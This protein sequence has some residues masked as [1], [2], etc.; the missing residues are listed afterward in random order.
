[1]T[2]GSKQ[3]TSIVCGLLLALPL[4][5]QDSPWQ[6][7]GRL[8]AH[9]EK[10]GWERAMACLDDGN[11]SCAEAA[12]NQLLSHTR[13]IG[14]YCLIRVNGPDDKRLERAFEALKADLDPDSSRM[15]S[16]LVPIDALRGQERYIAINTA[17]SNQVDMTI[18][19][20]EFMARI[21]ENNYS[22]LHSKAE[23]GG[24]DSQYELAMA[25]AN[26]EM[27]GIE[28]DQ[29]LAIQWFSRAAAQGYAPAEF[30]MGYSYE[31]GMGVPKDRIQASIWYGKAADHGSVSSMYRLGRLLSDNQSDPPDDIS[32]ANRLL[33][34]AADAGLPDAQNSIGIHYQYGI[35]FTQSYALATEWYR[36]AADQGHSWAQ[37]NLGMLAEEGLGGPK[38]HAA[39]VRWYEQAIA[40]DHPRAKWK[41]AY[42]LAEG[43]GV[44]QDPAR[45]KSLFEQAA[46]AGEPDGWNGL[47]Y[48]FLNGI[49]VN[50]SS[51]EALRHYLRSANAGNAHGMYR[52]SALL[53]ER[54]A[55]K[56][57]EWRTKAA[58]LG[59]VDAQNNN[60]A[61]YETGHGVEINTAWALY[62]YAKA[63]QQGSELAKQNIENL[64]PKRSHLTTSPNRANLR[65]EPSTSASV[66]ESLPRGTRV[67]PLDEPVPGWREVYVESG[68][69]LGYLSSSVLD[70]PNRRRGGVPTA[71]ND[72]WPARP[73]PRPGYVT[74]NT[75]CRNGDCRR[76]YSDGRRVRFQ[77]T[78]K[79]NPFSSQFEWDSGSC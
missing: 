72:G 14:E 65:A 11:R 42:L 27:P 51:T 16:D 62:W 33:L 13:W 37:A 47:G 28:A 74:C 41:L 67:Y 4:A 61:A 48:L 49:G 46:A 50:K 1:M 64:L 30:S 9:I 43:S 18:W 7:G 79:W 32:R 45:A 76:T 31:H 70:D 69:R 22:I 23:E 77:A 66:L 60:G 34:A 5:A 29:A 17:L 20:S 35:G 2:Y 26:G 24:A 63:A 78:Q 3:L 56:A 38:D 58:E 54:D 71:S 36:K 40:Q 55:R 44:S 25:Y 52:A 57:F 19:R 21:E 10:A 53:D 15:K 73:E 6:V 68:H 8:E 39:A 75:N 12:C 59:H